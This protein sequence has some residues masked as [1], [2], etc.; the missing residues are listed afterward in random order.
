M[1]FEE[2]NQ[3][4]NTLY[5]NKELYTFILGKKEFSKK[6]F[7]VHFDFFADI[8]K[9]NRNCDAFTDPEIIKTIK[10]HAKIWEKRY[11]K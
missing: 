11:I 5:N 3:T 8:I 4:L 10:R 9:A 6:V 2:R 7:D 1:T